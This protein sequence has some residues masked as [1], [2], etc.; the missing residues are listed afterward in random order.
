MD[1]KTKTRLLALREEAEMLLGPSCYSLLKLERMTP[2]G[3]KTVITWDH[4][5]MTIALPTLCMVTGNNEEEALRSMIL[6]EESMIDND[7]TDM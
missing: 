3:E 2:E 7:R 1:E 5:P 6:L 4:F